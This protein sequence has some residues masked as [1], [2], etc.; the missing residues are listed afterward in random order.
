MVETAILI[1]LI[2]AVAIVL[3]K[4]VDK[5]GQPDP[6]PFVVKLVILLVALIAIASRLGYA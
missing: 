4:L 1:V 2:I 5:A 6:I 3:F